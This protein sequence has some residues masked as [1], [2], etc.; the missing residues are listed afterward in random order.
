ME[1]FAKEGITATY[2]SNTSFDF[3]LLAACNHTISS[4]G[5]FSM[6]AASFAGGK[7]INEHSPGF[8]KFREI[9]EFNKKPALQLRDISEL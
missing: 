2:N 9:Y 8:N 7:I 4:R 3:A 5:T 6:F 1:N